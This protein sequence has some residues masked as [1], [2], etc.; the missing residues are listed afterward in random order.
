MNHMIDGGLTGYL[1]LRVGQVREDLVTGDARPTSCDT[2][3]SNFVPICVGW[4]SKS[5][6][7]GNNDRCSLHP[8]SFRMF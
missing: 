6:F 4:A 2:F 5:L 8:E 7:V 1:Q 3:L